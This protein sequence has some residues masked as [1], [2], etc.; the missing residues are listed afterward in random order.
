M[1]LESG[2]GEV[3]LAEDGR[4]PAEDGE[5]GAI[6]I[7]FEGQ[8]KAAAT[9]RVGRASGMETSSIVRFVFQ[10]LIY[11]SSE[12]DGDFINCKIRL[13]DF[14]PQLYDTPTLS[15]YLA[16]TPDAKRE[17]LTG[18]GFQLVTK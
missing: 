17:R 15:R 9:R 14:N 13:P 3:E 8:M 7:R 10:I 12:R 18:H 11:N 6:V 4:P 16:T 1:R 5:G 2:K